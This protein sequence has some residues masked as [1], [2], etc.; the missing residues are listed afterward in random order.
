[1]LALPSGLL[2]LWLHPVHIHVLG[3]D[4]HKCWRPKGLVPFHLL[5][6][7]LIFIISGPIMY[8]SVFSHIVYNHLAMMCYVLPYIR[9]ILVP[10][11]PNHF[12]IVLFNIM[13]ATELA[14]LWALVIPTVMLPWDSPACSCC[15]NGLTSFLSISIVCYNYC[16]RVQFWISYKEPMASVPACLLAH[17]HHTM[18]ASW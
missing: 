18:F 2:S 8:H 10:F 4:I 3:V 6:C 11:L 17:H 15:V 12:S 13:L 14:V 5:S 16:I 9:N 1:M 7:F